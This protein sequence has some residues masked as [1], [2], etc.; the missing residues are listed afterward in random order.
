MGNQFN[1]AKMAAFSML[2]FIG[3][4][5]KEFRV[6]MYGLDSA[7]KTTILY[8]QVL[9]MTIAGNP[10]VGFNVEKICVNDIKLILWDVSFRDKGIT[11]YFI[12]LITENTC[13]N[14]RP[15]SY[16]ALLGEHASVNFGF[17]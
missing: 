7:G 14:L 17:G 9:G 11:K 4:K 8:R 1:T 15:T 3:V 16:Q 12:I 10:T 13:L 2:E 5:P 6:L